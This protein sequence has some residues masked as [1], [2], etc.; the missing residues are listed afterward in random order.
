MNS[1]KER[2]LVVEDMPDNLLVLQATLEHEG[3]NVLTASDSEEAL[4]LLQKGANN[5]DLVLS[6]VMMPGLSGYDLCRCLRCDPKF[7]HLPVVLITAKRVNEK[8]VLLGMNVGADDYLVRPIDPNLLNKKLRLLLDRKWELR[9]WQDKYQQKLEELELREWGTRMLVHDIRNPLTGAM[10]ALGLLEMESNI[11]DGQRLLI[12]NALNCLTKQRDML[13]DILMTAA[14]QNGTLTL[15]RQ[16]FD[17]GR[18]VQEQIR[19]QQDIANREQFTFH[20]QGLTDGY[21]V[22]ADRELLSRVF[23]NLIMNSLKYGKRGSAVNIWVGRPE[24]SHWPIISKGRLAFV[25]ANQGTPIPAQDQ[26]RIFQAFATG[27]QPDSQNGS[28]PLRSS[29]IGLGL[30]FC[31]KVIELHGG[32]INV[33]S[34]LPGLD[35]G[36]AFYLTMP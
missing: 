9:K 21:S 35:D 29:G 15:R 14:A 5:V 7:S 12:S 25:I 18:C 26:E 32:T 17:L 19:L 33:I 34:P 3:Y 23:A 27:S 20:C 4:D 22:E 13:Q 11:T 10:A 28:R 36:V 30:C 16:V 6:D 2:I 1:G 31:L 24:E 8:D